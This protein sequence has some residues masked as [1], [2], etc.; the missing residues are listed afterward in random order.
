MKNGRFTLSLDFELH[1]G[2]W[3]TQ[4]FESYRPNL[5]GARTVIPR[6]LSLFAARQL[7]CTWAVVG[8]LCFENQTQL[9]A[10]LPILRP[11][12]LR[13]SSSP[14]TL[15]EQL[16]GQDES[17][18]PCH[19]AD[20]L[21]RQIAATP[22]QELGTH[23][24]SHF[25]CMEPGQTREEF[26]HDLLA[27]VR[28]LKRYKCQPVSIVFPRNQCRY[29]DVCQEVGLRCYREDPR[30][31]IYNPDRNCSFLLLRRALKLLDSYINLT[32]HNLF[33]TPPISDAPINVPASAVLRAAPRQAW[34]KLLEPIRL[35]RIKAAMTAAAKSGQ[36][37]HLYWHPHN[38]GIQQ[39]ANL[40]FLEQVLD[41]FEHLKASYGFA[42]A[43]MSDFANE[44]TTHS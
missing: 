12:Y 1:W 8:F 7:R 23:T 21:V 30:H 35:H 22:G 37:Y 6:L 28:A 13:P 15:V 10:D 42:S 38:F 11:G 9:V 16:A 20:S 40:H 41:H 36:N 31:W 32:G 5:L 4:D 18:S 19:F 33:P 43:C 24:F 25:S 2:T 26:R 44:R 3:D 34:R 29:L 27:A 39:D 17:S 14:Y